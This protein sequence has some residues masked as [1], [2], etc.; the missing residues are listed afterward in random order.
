MA[1]RYRAAAIVGPAKRLVTACR[2]LA[3]RIWLSQAPAA[4]GLAGAAVIQRG[5]DRRLVVLFIG[6]ADANNCAVN[7]LAT[8][9]GLFGH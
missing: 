8:V 1:K 7:I 5:P 6:D 3:A 2:P 9:S 4:C